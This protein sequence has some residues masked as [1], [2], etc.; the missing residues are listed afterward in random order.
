MKLAHKQ[1]QKEQQTSGQK[2]K[3]KTVIRQVYLALF[4]IMPTV[5][6]A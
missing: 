6:P 2:K 4:G 5:L 3:K 1:L